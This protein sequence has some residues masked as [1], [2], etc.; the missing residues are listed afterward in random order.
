MFVKISWEASRGAFLEAV[1]KPPERAFW[2]LL[3]PLLGLLGASSGPLG[4]LFW[5]S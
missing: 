4:G 1:V 5:A 2:G 3:G